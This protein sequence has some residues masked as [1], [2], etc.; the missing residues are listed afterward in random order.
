MAKKK[1]ILDVDF[2]GGQGALTS[3]EE[4][5]LSEYLKKAKP[6]ATTKSNRSRILGN[7]KKL[8]TV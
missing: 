1:Q 7:R 3:I 6:K 5:A 4:K 2:I 8:T